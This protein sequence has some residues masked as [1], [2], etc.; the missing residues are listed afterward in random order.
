M[1]HE[2]HLVVVCGGRLS[3]SLIGSLSVSW[4]SSISIRRGSSSFGVS[5]VE[6]VIVGSVHGT[7]VGLVVV[8]IVLRLSAS[9]GVMAGLA[10]VEAFG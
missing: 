2:S 7:I 1:G 5:M 4:G 10:A 8:G 3:C 6:A 9:I